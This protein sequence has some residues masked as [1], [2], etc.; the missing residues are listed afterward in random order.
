MICVILWH[1]SHLRAV[2]HFCCHRDVLPSIYFC[3]KSNN[4]YWNPIKGMYSVAHLSDPQNGI[5]TIYNHTRKIAP[6]WLFLFSQPIVGLGSSYKFGFARCVH[7]NFKLSGQ[8]QKNCIFLKFKTVFAL[9]SHIGR[10][11]VH[12]LLH[13]GTRG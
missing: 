7:V 8:S 6:T 2:Y 3:K 9:V 10:R 12:T 11:H 4:T 5:D 1:L 13:K